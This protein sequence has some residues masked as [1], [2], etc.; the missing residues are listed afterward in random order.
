MIFCCLCHSHSCLKQCVNFT[1]QLVTRV[2]AET[3]TPRRHEAAAERID[4]DSDFRA[5]VNARASLRIEARMFS[6]VM[7]RVSIALMRIRCLDELRI[8]MASRFTM[9]ALEFVTRSSFFF[10]RDEPSLLSLAHRSR[11]EA[12][13]YDLL[14]MSTLTQLL[15]AAQLGRPSAIALLPCFLALSA[16]SLFASPCA[17]SFLASASSA[18]SS[19]QAQTPPRSSAELAEVP[20]DADLLG[21]T[22][23]VPSGST[24]RVEK[25]PAASYLVSDS[26]EVPL[27]RLRATSLRASRAET[28]AKTQCDE[29]L[30]DLTAREQKFD[31]LVNE[32]R[33]IAGT[34]AHLFYISVALPAG[35][36]GISGTLIIP[37]GVDN[38]LVFSILALEDRFAQSRALLDR[39]FATIELKDVEKLAGARASLL[40]IGSVMTSLFTEQALRATIHP[41][42]RFYRMWKPGDGSEKKDFGYMAVRVREGKRGEVDASKDARAFKGEDAD[43]GLLATVDARVVVNGDATHTL[44]VQSRYFMTFDRAS[45]SWSMRSTERQKRA[46]RSSAQTGFRAAPSVGAP[47]PKIRVITATR[48]GMTREPQEWSLPPVYLSQVELIVLGELLPRV[49]DAERIEFADYA[50]DQREEKLPQRRET[51]TPTTEGWRLETLAGSSPAPLLQDF[52]SKGRRVRRIDVD[53]TVTEFIELAALRTLWKSKGLPVE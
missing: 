27:W 43:V 49:P 45:E 48:D 51:W 36:V 38:Y 53:G 23:R 19:A 35:G 13:P 52:D 1:C 31:V 21:F 8:S 17:P 14:A 28:S 40:G 33:S 2:C 42:P 39:A 32:P 34:N 37:H 30:A 44:D 26:S 46:E 3:N 16:Q 29:Y 20:L 4:E 22:V 41:E 15:N 5:A 50:F 12:T 18:Q 47:R 9:C 6:C 7:S 10:A 25:L 24:V 11:D